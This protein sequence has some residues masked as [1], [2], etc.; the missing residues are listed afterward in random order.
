[1]R[2]V[3]RELIMTKVNN[4]AELISDQEEVKLYQEA[5]KKIKNNKKIETLISQIKL[6]QQELVNAKHLK[7]TNYIKKL[8][9]ELDKLNAELNEIPLVKQYQQT[10]I[11]LNKYLQSVI[12]IIKDQISDIVPLDNNK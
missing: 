3:N 2:Q 11:E 7:K 10:Q 4:L 5:E 1:M 6:K 8:E 9:Q 12:K